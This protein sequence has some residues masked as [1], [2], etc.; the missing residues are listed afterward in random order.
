MIEPLTAD[1]AAVHGFEQRAVAGVEIGRNDQHVIAGV[2]GIDG[3]PADAA[4][5][6]VQARQGRHVE[7]VGHDDSFESHFFFEQSVHNCP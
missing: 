7:G 2:E 5:V 3:G 4:I 1:F 6:R